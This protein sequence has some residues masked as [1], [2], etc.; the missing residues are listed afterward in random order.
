MILRPG[1]NVQ[2]KQQTFKLSNFSYGRNKHQLSVTFKIMSG[3]TLGLFQ[4]KI[5][6]G[7]GTPINNLGYYHQNFNYFWGTTT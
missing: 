4:K 1:N 2:T 6:G 5:P 3:I 7:V